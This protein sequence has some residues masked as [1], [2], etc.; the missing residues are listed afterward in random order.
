MKKNFL[1][2]IL[3]LF[4]LS[5]FSQEIIEMPDVT[6]I[7]SGSEQELLEDSLPDFSDILPVEEE[8]LPQLESNLPKVESEQDAKFSQDFYFEDFT[9]FEGKIFE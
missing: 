9:Y 8:L 3:F 5:V 2:C 7:I 1:F 4:S 6:T